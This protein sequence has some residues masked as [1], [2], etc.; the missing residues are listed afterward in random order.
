MSDVLCTLYEKHYHYG[1]GAL[2]N[3]LAASGFDGIFVIGFRG[4]DAPWLRQCE[5]VGDGRYRLQTMEIR[6]V[7]LDDVRLH[8]T[9]YK[10]QFMLR[11]FAEIVPEAIRL[12]YIDPDI[13]V[14]ANWRFFQDWIDHGVALCVDVNG[15]VHRTSPLRGAWRRHFEPAGF[16]FHGR[17]DCYVNGGFVGVTPARAGILREWVRAQE[18]MAPIIGGLSTAFPADRSHPFHMTDQDALNAVLDCT[19]EHLAILGPEGMDFAPGGFVMSHALGLPKPWRKRY[20]IAALLGNPP[21]PAD[22]LFWKQVVTPLRI[23]PMPARIWNAVA[24]RLSSLLGRFWRR[25]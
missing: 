24:I 11:I 1:V 4:P 25:A 16:A 6:L 21:T 22:K 18:V 20:L 12:A 14:R 9:N 13:V 19:D 15:F 3:S 17:M 8:F 2:L 23:M 10:P 7:R 5:H